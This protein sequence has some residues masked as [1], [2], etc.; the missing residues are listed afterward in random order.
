MTNETKILKL[1]TSI[2]KAVNDFEYSDLTKTVQFT[3]SDSLF[4]NDDFYVDRITIPSN[5]VDEFLE[6]YELHKSYV[7]A[8][9]SKIKSCDAK[10]IIVNLCDVDVT[11]DNKTDSYIITDGIYIKEKFK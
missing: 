11:Y 10:L 3:T 9:I 6:D 2:N 8:K 7:L 4:E 1:Y 5:L